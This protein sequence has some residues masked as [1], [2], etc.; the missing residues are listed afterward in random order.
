V[1]PVDDG[2]VEFSKSASLHVSGMV[3]LQYVE[4]YAVLHSKDVLR[5]YMLRIFHCRCNL[6]SLSSMI[7]YQH[8]V[9]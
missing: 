5:M 6:V 9:Y 4:K 2:V 1:V 7:S 3:V 8:A